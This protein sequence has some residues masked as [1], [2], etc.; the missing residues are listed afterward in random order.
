MKAEGTSVDRAT[1]RPRRWISALSIA[2]V[3]FLSI[4]GSTSSG[5]GSDE[6][7]AGGVTG[8]VVGP[9][10]EPVAGAVVTF[11]ADGGNI[12]ISVITDSAGRYEIARLPLGAY[13]ISA[14]A[15]GYAPYSSEVVTK[16]DESVLAIR[17]Q[18]S[19]TAGWEQA[20]SSA[21]LS[22]LP[23]GETKRRFILDCAGCHPFDGTIVRRAG[24]V[25]VEPVGEPASASADDPDA[26]A[27]AAAPAGTWE[28]KT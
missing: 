9:A 21:Y 2:A 17:L 15:V 4:A 25:S 24:S 19:S 28:P 16:I 12:A 5:Y 11:R 3:G 22:L 20:P 7:G 26:A 14:S 27:S 18:T 10:S 1:G 8:V 13:T 23:D 6:L